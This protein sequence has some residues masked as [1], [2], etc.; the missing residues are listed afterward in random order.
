MSAWSAA[1]PVAPP[2]P[3]AQ[4]SPVARP[5][6]TPAP[7]PIARRQLAEGLAHPLHV[8]GVAL[9]RLAGVNGQ[10]A[11]T[12]DWV[13]AHPRV[14]TV[15]IVWAP[16]APRGGDPDTIVAGLYVPATH[17][18]TISEALRHERAEVIAAVLAH[19]LWHAI[20]HGEPF[21]SA[22]ACFQGEREAKVL[23][24]AVW[25]VLRPDDAPRTG[26]ERR[27]DWQW[28]TLHTSEYDEWFV[29]FY[30]PQC[31]PYAAEDLEVEMELDLAA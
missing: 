10:P 18:I 11:G 23:E 24:T 4:P 19:E 22:T 6:A 3:A 9:Q 2:T 21:P 17:T 30:T 7:P 28:R 16:L 20:H 1:E 26:I 14:Q 15:N 13:L 29:G 8:V 12:Y 25:S 27:M 5:P 31:S